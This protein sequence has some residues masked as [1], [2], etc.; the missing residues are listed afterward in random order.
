MERSRGNKKTSFKIKSPFPALGT[1][2]GQ[3][4]DTLGETENTE[5]T[6]PPPPPNYDKY[7]TGGNIKDGYDFEDGKKWHEKKAFRDSGIGHIVDA[8]KVIR[9]G[10]KDRKAKKAA[11]REDEKVRGRDAVAAMDKKSKEDYGYLPWEEGYTSE[12]EVQYD[13]GGKPIKRS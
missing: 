9:K 4:S 12:N 1:G 13:E 6:P 5:T 3:L 10:I 2:S 11:K 8:V 7:E